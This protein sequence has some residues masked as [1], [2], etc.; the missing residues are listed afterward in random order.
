[1]YDQ[2]EG[3]KIDGDKTMH[4]SVTETIELLSEIKDIKQELNIISSVILAQSKV[5]EQLT[6]RPRALDKPVSASRDSEGTGGAGTA[7]Y[8]LRRIS[9]LLRFAEETQENVSD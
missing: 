9:G 7:E 8:V 6:N 3:K 5:W 2:D 4:S 1:M